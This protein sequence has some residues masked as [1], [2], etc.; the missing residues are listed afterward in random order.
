MERRVQRASNANEIYKSRSFKVGEINQSQDS[1]AG[2]Y[3]NRLSVAV[4]QGYQDGQIGAGASD[5]DSDEEGDDSGGEER[6]SGIHRHISKENGELVTSRG[7]LI[8]STKLKA[9]RKVAHEAQDDEDGRRSSV[10]MDL[11]MRMVSRRAKR[12]V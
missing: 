10:K 2:A 8:N 3:E 1:D 9:I 4:S 12:W 7:S 5:S 6:S 11:D